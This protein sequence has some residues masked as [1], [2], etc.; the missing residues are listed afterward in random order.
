MSMNLQYVDNTASW[1]DDSDAPPSGF[2]FSDTT[3][4]YYSVTDIF[5]WIKINFSNDL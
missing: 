4:K 2:R 3:L 5:I 1:V